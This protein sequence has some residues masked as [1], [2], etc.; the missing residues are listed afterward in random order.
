MFKQFDL[1]FCHT[2]FAMFQILS[3]SRFVENEIQKE[4]PYEP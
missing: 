3:I 2:R 4:K 1:S